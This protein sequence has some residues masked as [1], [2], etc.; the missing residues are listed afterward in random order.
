MDYDIWLNKAIMK[1]GELDT[2]TIFV[3]KDLFSGVEWNQLKRG[4]KSNM[5]RI[6]K[7]FVKDKKI[8]NIELIESPNGT[9]NTYKKIKR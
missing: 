2:E 9:S 4:E 6:F 8:P 3:L 5:G 1:I 7:N